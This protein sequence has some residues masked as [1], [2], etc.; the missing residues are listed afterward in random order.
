MSAIN[1]SA[2]KIVKH[3]LAKEGPMTTQK[4][5]QYLPTYEKQFIS[6][7]HLKTKVLKS[8]ESQGEI[9]KVINRDSGL[10]KPVWEWRFTNPE[11]A[12][13]FKILK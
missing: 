5:F 8:M 13:K 3:L 4:F 9:Q 12:E 2:G 6:K 10:P 1:H 11:E 7:T